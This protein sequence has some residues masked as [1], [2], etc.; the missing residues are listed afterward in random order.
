MAKYKNLDTKSV[1]LGQ[2]AQMG[3]L[4]GLYISGEGYLP[5]VG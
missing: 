2:P 4:A 1:E 5:L 3:M